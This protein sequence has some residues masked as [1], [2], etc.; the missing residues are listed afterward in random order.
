M[1]SVTTHT[2]PCPVHHAEVPPRRWFSEWCQYSGFT[3][4]ERRKKARVEPQQAPG[5]RPGPIDNA[6]L[7]GEPPVCARPS[8]VGRRLCSSGS[9]LSMQPGSHLRV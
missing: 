8:S 5:P 1:F 3:Y 4:D 2:R 6:D 9:A 7:L